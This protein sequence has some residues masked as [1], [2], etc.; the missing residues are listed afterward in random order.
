MRSDEYLSPDRL[1]PKPEPQTGLP[2]P[3]RAPVE[4]GGGSSTGTQQQSSKPSPP[5]GQGPALEWH[6]ASSRRSVAAGIG[7]MI[8][9]AVGVTIKQDGSLDWMSIWWVWLI[10]LVVGVLVGIT[11]R[12]DSCTAGADWLSIG[13]KWVSIYELTSVKVKVPANYRLLQLTDTG[14]RRV[15]ISLNTVQENQDLWDFVYNGILHS[16][17]NGNAET[18]ALA[19]R[20]LKLPPKTDDR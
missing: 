19:R 10:V 6:K 3:P 1:P 15:S 8:L 7:A 11:I 12:A 20:S 17:V 16:V 4:P 13:K 14:G 5:A 2:R 9:V 18:N